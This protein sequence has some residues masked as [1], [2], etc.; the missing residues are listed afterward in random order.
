MTKSQAVSEQKLR[1]YL[2]RVKR[3]EKQQDEKEKMHIKE[4]KKLPLPVTQFP[5]KL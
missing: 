4:L 1:E 2:K 5:G 3:L